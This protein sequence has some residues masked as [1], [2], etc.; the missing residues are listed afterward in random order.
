MPKYIRAASCAYMMKVISKE[1]IWLRPPASSQMRKAMA[2]LRSELA[3]LRAELARA[4][5]ARAHKTALPELPP[6]VL[7]CA[8]VGR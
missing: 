7:A 3:E 2:E 4:V 6:F 8:R 1:M 5:R